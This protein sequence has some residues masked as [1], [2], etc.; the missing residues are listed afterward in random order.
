MFKMFVTVDRINFS[1]FLSVKQH[2]HSSSN[3]ENLFISNFKLAD[4]FVQTTGYDV[5][6]V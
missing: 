4:Y 3:V 2:L 1:N 5:S 6:A